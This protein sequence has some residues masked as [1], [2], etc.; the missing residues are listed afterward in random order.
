MAFNK[1]EELDLKYN[2]MTN[3]VASDKKRTINEISSTNQNQ[4][5][6]PFA[7]DEPKSEQTSAINSSAPK[8]AID[9]ST[10]EKPVDQDEIN[11][12]TQQDEKMEPGE[13]ALE[14]EW[15]LIKQQN[16]QERS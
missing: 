15:K 8:S 2:V 14:K 3:T 12:V 9:T 1:E 13:S 10:V 4:R 5:K 7:K 6:N 16:E 11:R